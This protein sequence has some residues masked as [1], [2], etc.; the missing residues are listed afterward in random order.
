MKNFFERVLKWYLCNFLYIS[1]FI[2]ISI[3]FILYGKNIIE[4]NT[5]ILVGILILIIIIGYL[6]SQLVISTIIY[7]GS[8]PFKNIVTLKFSSELKDSLDNIHSFIFNT[9]TQYQIR[10]SLFLIIL[11]LTL[12]F[13]G[14][15]PQFLYKVVLTSQYLKETL[16]KSEI[17]PLAFIGIMTNIFIITFSLVLLDKILSPILKIEE[18]LT[19]HQSKEETIYEELRTRF[20]SHNLI[21]DISNLKVY[22]SI[23]KQEEPQLLG[24]FSILEDLTAMIEDTITKFRN[25]DSIRTKNPFIL[26]ELFD[27]FLILNEP[28]LVREESNLEIIYQISDYKNLEI[29]QIFYEVYQVLNNLI[30]NARKAIAKTAHKE[31][32]IFTLVETEGY[33]VFQVSDTGIGID[34]KSRNRIFDIGYST[35][36]GDGLG[37]LF[38][39]TTLKRFGGEIRLLPNAL[40]G[41]STTFEVKIPFQKTTK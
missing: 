6:T 31:I 18:S 29:H 30:S 7:S 21:N 28:D 10:V 22:I 33:V 15:V 36:N 14:D 27:N 19:P 12:F 23:L 9:F 34:S 24:K 5:N 35:T 39:Q 11:F 2:I 3:V 41:F 4:K 13:V 40:S 20:T 32:Q 25:S 1:G 17:I 37:L 38:V 16:S 8:T 26:H